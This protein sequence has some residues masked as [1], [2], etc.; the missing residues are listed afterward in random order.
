[1][2]SGSSLLAVQ[3]HLWAPREDFLLIVVAVVVDAV[4][5]IGAGCGDVVA[6]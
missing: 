2:W 4:G 1:M 3:R 5:D 6:E